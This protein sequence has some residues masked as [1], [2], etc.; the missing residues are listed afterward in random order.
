MPLT[1][2]GF[3][4]TALG[5]PE[6][7][8]SAHMGHPDF[9]VRG[10]KIFATLWPK[11]GWGVLILTPEQQ[12][13]FVADAPAMFVPVKGGWGRRGCTHV[14]LKKA[15]RRSLKIALAVAWRNAAPRKLV[16]ASARG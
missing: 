5:F 2:E 3:R 16:E 8:E 1:L 13:G 6:A 7:F 9:R 12:E 14:I 11:E 10:G 4:E 15:T